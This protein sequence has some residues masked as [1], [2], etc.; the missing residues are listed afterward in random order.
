[1]RSQDHSQNGASLAPE[2]EALE[3]AL[4]RAWTGAGSTPFLVEAPVSAEISRR[5][6]AAIRA[7]RLETLFSR[8]PTLAVWGVLTPLARGYDDGREVY[9]HIGAFIREDL[10]DAL[11]RDA[12]K[13]RF[14]AA[15]RR[16]GLPVSG[17][18]PT[19]LFFAPLGPPHSYHDDLAEAFVG[20]ALSLGPPAIEDTPSARRWQRLAVTIARPG[21]TRLLATIQFDQ[22]A[23]CARR[24]TTWRRGEAPLGEAEAHL[25]AAYDA[26]LARRGRNRSD[27]LTVAE[28]NSAG[29]A[30]GNE[31]RAGRC[32]PW[33]YMRGCAGRAMSMG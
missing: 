12:L 28:Q 15:A 3:T 17:N 9:R 31:L 24:F 30:R 23:W 29:F 1:M 21:H 7:V 8:A 5:A 4:T 22:A 18:D 27:N 16:I 14:R 33:T 10:D 13:S 26:A 2:I 25:F 20:A 19:G 32:I 11:S 6:E